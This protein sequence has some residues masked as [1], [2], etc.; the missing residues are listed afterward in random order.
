MRAEI[1]AQEAG[2]LGEAGEEMLKQAAAVNIFTSGLVEQERAEQ[3]SKIDIFEAAFR[4]IKDSTGVS[5]VNEV[6]QK[7]ISQE[8]TTENLMMLTKENQSKIESL[9]ESRSVLKSK[10]EEIKYSG[11]GGGHRRK[12]VDDHEEQLTTSGARLER[13][14]LKYERLA[15]MLITA[16]A[17]V[18]HL[19]DK[20]T[21]VGDELG[22]QLIEMTDETVVSVLIEAERS[23]ASM[24]S[25]IRATAE[26]MA[27]MGGGGDDGAPA[28]LD[29][30]LAGG[31][32]GPLSQVSEAEVMQSRPYNQRIELPSAD[33]EWDGDGMKADD[34]VPDVDEDELTRD[35]VKKAASQILIAQE[36]RHRVKGKRR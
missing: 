1:H 28:A 19:Q 17:G 20:L 5:D 27:I 34:G 13:C 11:P 9:N 22:M 21:P 4:K 18:K 35:K 23:L 30:A 14:R 12:M 26:E 8:G 31:A 16:K 7:I 32:G 2:D 29:L 10:V 25:R 24:V 36:K 6:I 15:K 33:D 3:R